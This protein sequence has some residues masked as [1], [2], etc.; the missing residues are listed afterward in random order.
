MSQENMEV[1]QEETHPLVQSVYDSNPL[2]EKVKDLPKL[3]SE[4]VHEKL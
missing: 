4:P 3:N 2:K 1:F